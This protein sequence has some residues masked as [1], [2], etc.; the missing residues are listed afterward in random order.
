VP[1][2]AALI[3]EFLTF[4][5]KDELARRYFTWLRD[6]ADLP[7]KIGFDRL[8]GRQGYADAI[9]GKFSRKAA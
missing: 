6:D 3:S 5:K 4:S 9:G 1:A 8:I 2:R 7:P